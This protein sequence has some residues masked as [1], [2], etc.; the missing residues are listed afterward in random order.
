MRWKRGIAILAAGAS[1]S[2]VPATTATAENFPSNIDRAFLK[3]CTEGGATRAVCKCTLRKIEKKYTLKQFE[4]ISRRV[5]RGGD[6]PPAIEKMA[7]ACAK[8]YG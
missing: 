5:D 3:G 2:L 6:L 7:A 1:I 8:K 4:R